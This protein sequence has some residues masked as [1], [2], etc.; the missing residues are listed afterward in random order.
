LLLAVAGVLLVGQ[1]TVRAQTKTQIAA[2]EKMEGSTKTVIAACTAV[3]DSS[4]YQ[5]GSGA[6]AYGNRAQA[7]IDTKQYDLAVRDSTTALELR[8]TA[9]AYYSRGAAY[10]FQEKFA[11]AVED[12]SEAVRMDPKFADAMQ[13]RSEAYSG[14]KKFDLALRDFDAATKMR[15]GKLSFS[16]HIDKVNIYRDAGRFEDALTEI[17]LAGKLDRGMA[18]FY[19]R[20]WTQYLLGKYEEAIASLTAGL[21]MQPDYAHALFRRGLSFEKVGER[22]DAAADLREASEK[23][24]RRSWTAEM[25]AAFERFNIR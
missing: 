7:Y 16:D 12:L 22:D 17:E 4:K 11:L 1:N 25:R 10:L 9:N 15:G 13:Y 14:L 19:H 5:G 23:I 24:D 2:C 3:I 18:Y 20:G 6:W 21:L 8:K